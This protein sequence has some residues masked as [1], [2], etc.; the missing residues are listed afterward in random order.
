MKFAISSDLDTF[1][2]KHDNIEVL[3]WLI[4]TDFDKL[5]NR[6]LKYAD[7]DMV[8]AL[9]LVDTEDIDEFLNRIYTII[10]VHKDKLKGIKLAFY[11]EDL[12][13][14]GLQQL[15]EWGIKFFYMNKVTSWHQLEEYKN[16]GV[17]DMYLVAEM[18]FGLEKASN[19]LHEAGIRIRVV[20]NVCQRQGLVNPLI[21]F[22]ILPEHV[23]L[24]EWYVDIMEI[25]EDPDKNVSV[26]YDVYAHQHRWFGKYEELI[27]DFRGNLNGQNLPDM[28][29]ERRIGCELKCLKG[30]NCHTCF[31]L[32]ELCK[33]L[34]EH[35][36]FISEEE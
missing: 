31:T 15:Q 3:K 4:P 9:K 24:Y 12:P 22:Y 27:T 18:G 25:V 6:I 36:I 1:R 34:T 20:P 11:K 21:G 35:N 29:A 17:C 32:D 7:Y 13:S 23:K 10:S 33:T 16:D 26:V 19:V 30:V 8:W 28:F 14:I 2:Y 5:E